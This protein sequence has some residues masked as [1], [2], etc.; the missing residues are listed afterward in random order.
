MRLGPEGASYSKNGGLDGTATIFEH[1]APDVDWA[2][3]LNSG[4]DGH[5]ADG[6]ARG[7]VTEA[8]RAEI[9]RRTRWPDVDYWSHYP[10]P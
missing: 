3:F 1:T 8:M 4:G 2:V 9:A 10:A 7:A 5:D 6:R